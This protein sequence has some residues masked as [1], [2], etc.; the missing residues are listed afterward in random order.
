MAKLRTI[1][2]TWVKLRIFWAISGN[3]GKNERYTAI[4]GNFPE[5]K[6]FQSFWGS[7]C[8]FGSKLLSEPRPRTAH[9]PPTD[10]PTDPPRTPTD[11]HG[12]P[13]DLGQ[14]FLKSP[15][16]TEFR[17]NFPNRP[18]FRQ[19]FPN[20]PHRKAITLNFSHENAQ[21][22]ICSPPNTSF[23]RISRNHPK[24][25]NFNTRVARN[26]GFAA[27]QTQSSTN[28]LAPYHSTQ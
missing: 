26:T 4:L 27:R 3:F 14:T 13:T 10:C 9:E 1:G 5:N 19:N 11:G 12:P 21:H 17:Q 6:D 25:L 2:V 18:Q 15:K 22:K 16:T 20:R 23:A 7:D 24:I 8:V 28:G